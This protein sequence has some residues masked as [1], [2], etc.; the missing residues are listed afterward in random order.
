ME[1]LT[2]DLEKG[3]LRDWPTGWIG[4]RSFIEGN[5]MCWEKLQLE[6]RIRKI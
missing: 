1:A 6:Q 4:A 3:R 2:N 5:E